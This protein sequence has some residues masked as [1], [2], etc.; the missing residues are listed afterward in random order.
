MTMGS[1]CCS[2]V[3]ASRLA[4]VNADDRLPLDELVDVGSEAVRR[5]RMANKISPASAESLGVFSASK[6]NGRSSLREFMRE[7]NVI[8]KVGIDDEA[9]F[10]A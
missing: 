9:E 1:C 3:C 5:V 2:E 7:R 10:D 8:P 6:S 4:V